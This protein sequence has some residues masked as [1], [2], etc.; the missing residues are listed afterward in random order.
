MAREELAELN[1]RIE[2]LEAGIRRRKA[3]LNEALAARRNELLI[4]MDRQIGEVLAAYAR[5]QGYDLVL[6][7]EVA[8]ASPRVDITSQVL[9]RLR[10]QSASGSAR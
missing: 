7:Q 6:T 2:A 3:E 1:R 10:R 9:E 8:F 4:E 5:E